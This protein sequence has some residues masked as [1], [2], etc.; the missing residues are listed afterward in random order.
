MKCSRSKFLSAAFCDVKQ[1]QDYITFFKKMIIVPQARRAFP[2]GHPY[3]GCGASLGGFRAA[4]PLQDALVQYLLILE[5][6]KLQISPA[7]L[8][9]SPSVS[10]LA[11]WKPKEKP[12]SGFLVSILLVE[13]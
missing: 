3:L 2:Q 13:T 5:D 12:N 6:A 10:F 7:R 9:N 8:G 1:F 4:E 11:F